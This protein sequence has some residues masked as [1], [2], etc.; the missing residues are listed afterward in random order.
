[1]AFSEDNGV[2][3][4]LVA[5]VRDAAKKVLYAFGLTHLSL[6]KIVEGEEKMTA[7]AEDYFVL[8]SPQVFQLRQNYP[9]PF[10]QGTVIRFNLSKDSAVDLSVFDVLG[11]KL[12]VLASG[13]YP[14][15]SH[16]IF[17]NGKGLPSGIYFYSL[18]TGDR[19]ETRRALILR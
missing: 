2:T 3:W 5:T 1:M 18:K 4:Q 12:L 11:Q 16:Q 9:N 7:V 14:V 17:W 6:W 10:N 13:K 8:A 15:G 19:T